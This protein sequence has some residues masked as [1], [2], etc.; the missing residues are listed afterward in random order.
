[1]VWLIAVDWRFGRSVGLLIDW[2]GLLLLI[3]GL[4]DRLVDWF[5][6]LLLIGCLDD[7]LVDWFGLL[8][9][10]GGLDDQLVC[11]LIGVAYCC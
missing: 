11:W 2:F 5:G 1:M 4:D 9:L 8:L 6:L 10:N 7:R 3:G